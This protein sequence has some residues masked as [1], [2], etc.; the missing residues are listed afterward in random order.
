M[1]A[2]DRRSGPPQFM[3]R[4]GPLFTM[5]MASRGE[6]V[7][8]ADGSVNAAVKLVRTKMRRACCL[9]RK[10]CITDHTLSA[11]GNVAFVGL[12]TARTAAPAGYV[13]IM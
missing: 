4:Y 8:G 3:I 9:V 11:F 1:V 5:E 7:S 6:I 10:K 2:L 13:N 12:G